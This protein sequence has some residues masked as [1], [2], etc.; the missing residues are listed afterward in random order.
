M[1]P[2]TQDKQRVVK[3]AK[4]IEMVHHYKNTAR[5]FEAIRAVMF[6][7]ALCTNYFESPVSHERR[8]NYQF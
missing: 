3:K 5:T 2:I 8:P 7:T 4:L 1:E 6:G